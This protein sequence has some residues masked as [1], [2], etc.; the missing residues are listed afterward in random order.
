MNFETIPDDRMI[1]IRTC[2]ICNKKSYIN[3]SKDAY[4][5]W[6]SGT[7][8]QKALPELTEDQREWLISGFCP[9]CFEEIVKVK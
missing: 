6:K 2:P 1:V 4:N 9:E 3:V 8:I 7:V 5:D